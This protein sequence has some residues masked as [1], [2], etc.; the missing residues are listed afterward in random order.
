MDIDNVHPYIDAAREI[1][2]PN[3]LE[4]AA[5]LAMMYYYYRTGH[6]F[7]ADRTA[8]VCKQSQ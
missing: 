6:V 1:N 2:E 8:L 4:Q 5:F 7:R 3:R